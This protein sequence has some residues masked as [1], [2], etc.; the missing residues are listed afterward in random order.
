MR[1]TKILRNCLR[2]VCD[3]YRSRNKTED[4]ITSGGW[5]KVYGGI[6]CALSQRQLRHSGQT[7]TVNMADY[8][9]KLF[10][11]PCCDI[12]AGDAVLCRRLAREI[13]YE[14]AGEPFHY[15]SHTE[16]ILRR[17]ERL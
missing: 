14:S 8:D 12:R 15:N 4:H 5:E 6:P 7:F 17:R 13:W 9:V 10:L 3:I 11:P 1:E 16:V 2:D